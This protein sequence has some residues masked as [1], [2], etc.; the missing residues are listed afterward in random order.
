MPHAQHLNQTCSGHYLHVS[1]F[2]HPMPPPFPFFHAP[3]LP[4]ATPSSSLTQVIVDKY[5]PMA[6]RQLSF[7]TS[8]APVDNCWQHQQQ[9]R[10]HLP[11]MLL[12]PP[13]LPPPCAAP[14][15]R[16][17]IAQWPSPTSLSPATL[18]T[19]LGPGDGMSTSELDE[20]PAFFSGQVLQEGSNPETHRSRAV[21]TPPPPQHDHHEGKAEHHQR[22]APGSC[23]TLYTETS[24]D[25]VAAA[26]VSVQVCPAP[27]LIESPFMP[28]AG[29]LADL[30]GR[31][32]QRRH[33]SRKV[34]DEEGDPA[35]GRSGKVDCDLLEGMDLEQL[36]QHFDGNHQMCKGTDGSAGP[37]SSGGVSAGTTV[38]AEEAILGGVAGKREEHVDRVED[39][40]TIEQHGGEFIENIDLQTLFQSFAEDLEALPPLDLTAIGKPNSIAA[41]VNPAARVP[42]PAHY[43]HCADREEMRMSPVEQSIKRSL[44]EEGEEFSYDPHTPEKKNFLSGALGLGQSRQQQQ[45]PEQKN[46]WAVESKTYSP[47]ATSEHECGTGSRLRMQHQAL[48]A[49]ASSVRHSEIL[50]MLPAPAKRRRRVK[51]KIKKEDGG[52]DD[53]VEEYGTSPSSHMPTRCVYLFGKT[54]TASDAGRLARIVLPRA[55]V[56]RYLPRCDN[57]HGIPLTVWDIHGNNFNVVLKYWMNGRPVA[58]RMWLLDQCQEVIAVLGLEPGKQLDFYKADDGRLVVQAK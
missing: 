58:K 24:P 38:I 18:A 23:D 46:Y 44:S 28:M 16:A 47:A 42:S 51:T 12:P 29:S 1:P 34:S 9:Q 22:I 49:A 45:V 50:A 30:D 2:Q 13:P 8:E 20:L 55:A 15:S 37:G 36:F 56:E 32:N 33:L 4:A 35:H 41:D 31:S 26:A 6:R 17:A 54:I 25:Q 48:A 3:P 19:L 40:D 39:D 27:L 21:A 43:P 10:R 7:H 57:K 14:A 53:E 11:S 52:E 5:A